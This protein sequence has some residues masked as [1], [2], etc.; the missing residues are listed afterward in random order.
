VAFDLTTERPSSKLPRLRRL[1]QGLPWPLVLL[2]A[3]ILTRLCVFVFSFYSGDEATYSALASKI[4]SGGWPYTDAVDHKPIGI[5]MTYALI[6]AVVGRNHLIFVRILFVL[7]VTVTGIILS[8]IAQRVSEKEE[9]RV[10]G[11][12]Y[13]FVSAW[14]SPGDVQAANTE[15]FL[16]CPLCCAALLLV[17]LLRGTT[18][19][20]HLRLIGVGVCTGIATMYKYQSVL[21]GCAW[22]M[23]VFFI[24]G[25]I[26]TRLRRLASLAIGFIVVAT[27]YVGTFY[28]SGNWDAFVFWG[29]SFNLQYMS[30][31]SGELMAWNALRYTL[32]T[33]FLWLPLLL[34]LTKPI[35][36]LAVLAL[37][38]LAM[39][40]LATAAGGRFFPHYYLMAL[41]PLCLLATPGACQ[42]SGWKR[43]LSY[44]LGV[45]FIVFFIAFSWLWYDVKPNLQRYD[46]A[47]RMVGS[48]LQAHSQP[49][50][51]VFVWGNSPEI[52]YYSN[53]VMGTRFPFCNY[54][55]GKIWG[56]PLD[57]LDA[58]GTE[59]F[60]VP[61]A[62]TEL[63][64]DLQKNPPLYIIDGGAGHLDRFDRH[65][66]ARYPQLA[67]WTESNYRLVEWVAGV[68]L[69][70]LE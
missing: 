59:R 64:E 45:A 34:C 29:W 69:Y 37:P 9:A 54:H 58:T 46:T 38:W 6:Y 48:W 55:T 17:P 8:T 14:G 16:N 32:W 63:M 70:R 24:G 26:G 3:A 20:E 36:P 5:E 25:S 13:I 47:Y 27:F 44:G 21:A 61:R 11:L 65:S 62:W 2:L 51:R 41:P 28:G 35:R 22:A 7:M 10:A 56:S 18:R 40:L 15:L 19:L 57:D 43:K 12:L 33:T 23:T 42:M 30:T 67:H 49:T 60:I 66:I 52:Y 4:L 39:L 1:F 68:P 31:L 50:D 53:R